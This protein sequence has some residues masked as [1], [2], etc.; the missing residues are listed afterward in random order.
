MI[1]IKN[2][3]KNRYLVNDKL[4]KTKGKYIEYLDN[5]TN[6]EKET[7]I[8]YMSKIKKII[9]K[10]FGYCYFYCNLAI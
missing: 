9:V 7:F 5:F 6:L 8:E 1:H 2:I 3:S 10:K 4:V